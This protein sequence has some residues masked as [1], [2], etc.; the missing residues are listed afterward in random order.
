MYKLSIAFLALIPAAAFAQQGAWEV[1]FDFGPSPSER[2]RAINLVHVW[3]GQTMKVLAMSY[4]SPDS[5]LW[6]PPPAGSPAGFSGIFEEAN[7]ASYLFCG[8]HSAM[9]DGRILHAG[10]V[11]VDN[12]D[13]FDPWRDIGDQWNKP[14]D[15]LDMTYKRWY[16]TL[17]TLADGR[18]LSCAGL[19]ASGGPHATIPELYDP[20]ANMWTPL[21]SAN[22]QQ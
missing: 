20:I 10:G 19:Q 18:V 2:T 4:D 22:R 14:L 1:P 7:V 6:T 8:G 17:T 11:Y 12:V 3:D 21:V 15:P 13:I 9:A 16:P 5:R